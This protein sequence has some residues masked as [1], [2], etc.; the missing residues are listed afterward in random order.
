MFDRDPAGPRHERRHDLADASGDGGNAVDAAVAVGFALAV[1][2]PSAGNLGGGGFM[3]IRNADGGVEGI[4]YRER[5]PLA[6]TKTMFLDA[7][8]KVTVENLLAGG[9][10]EHFY[11][12]ELACTAGTAGDERIGLSIADVAG[13]GLP[14][15]LLDQLDLK[16]LRLSQDS[17]VD[18]HLEKL[19]SDLVYEV[20]VAGR[21]GLGKAAEK[22]L[23]HSAQRLEFI[24]AAGAAVVDQRPPAFRAQLG[25]LA[26]GT[27]DVVAVAGHRLAI[28]RE[29]DH[30]RDQRRVVGDG[31]Q[32][33]EQAGETHARPDAGDGEWVVPYRVRL[34][35]ARL[36]LVE[37]IM[38]V[39]PPTA[40][41]PLDIIRYN[42]YPRTT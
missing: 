36:G 29:A 19:F 41:A 24:L 18:E 21:D 8:G 9:F 15:A 30:D 23:G 17:F 34:D 27:G 39:R 20:E 28:D 12:G 2:W 7:N 33:A 37:A 35:Q 26:V 11:S 40:R 5:A 25:R 1:T 22:V 10:K 16:S 3:L 14:A 42:T 38:G 4:D 31:E 32:R 6:A 13:K